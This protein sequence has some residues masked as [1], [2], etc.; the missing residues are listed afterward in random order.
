M[1]LTEYFLI[2]VYI[3]LA[4]FLIALTVF[5][6]KLVGVVKQLNSTI[7]RNRNDIDASLRSIRET[8]ENVSGIT[9]KSDRLLEDVSPDIRKVTGAVGNTASNVD[10]LV[11]DVTNTI[12][13]VAESVVDGADALRQ[14]VTGHSG[15]KS[16]FYDVVNYV[17]SLFKRI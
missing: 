10:G 16:Y 7:E 13:F 9:R 14:K 1:A 5:M 11:S 3:C 17:I 2:L 4:A 15:I 12:D 8:T 6:F